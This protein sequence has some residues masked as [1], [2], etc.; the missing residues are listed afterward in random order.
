MPPSR[1][2]LL[3]E[4]RYDP[5]DRLIGHT[6]PN[7]PEHQRFYC[8]SR[9]ATEVQGAVRHSIMQHGNLLVAQQRRQEDESGV[10]LLVTDQQ[11]SV[12]HTLTPTTR[13]PITYSPYGCCG[14][15]SGLTSLLGFNGERPDS[16]TGHYLLGLG[17]RAFNP[18]L[19]RFN[20]PD[21]WSPFGKGGLNSYVYCL[22]DPINL[23]DPNGH[24]PFKKI[25]RSF[26]KP[27][28]PNKVSAIQKT[29][30][31]DSSYHGRRHSSPSLTPLS[32]SDEQ[33]SNWD[34]IGFHGTSD[35]YSDSLTAGLDPKY[36]GKSTN[37]LLGEGFYFGTRDIAEMFSYSVA[38]PY[39]PMSF[40]RPK[41]FGVY[42]E[43]FS[44]LNAGEDYLFSRSIDISTSDGAMNYRE[45]VAKE[46]IYKALVIR[47]AAP[48]RKITRPRSYET[49]LTSKAAVNV[50]KIR[51]RFFKKNFKH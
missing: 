3:C 24:N 35:K 44:K 41:I 6:Q 15:E 36:M 1:K 34:L 22:A 7:T 37:M 29:H 5:L 16:V 2:A 21:R 30:N 47:N 12:L 28:K 27:K 31:F 46:H 8:T 4:Y 33:L 51:S 19:M 18:V 10:T 17:Y 43:N 26:K 23:I 32:P 48:E 25:L 42:T 20:S 11:R 40:G 50:E 38:D 9:L 49:P 45:I 13:Q 39:G 14:T